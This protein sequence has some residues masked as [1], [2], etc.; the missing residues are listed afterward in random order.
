MAA[1]YILYS[2][3]LKKFYIGSCQEVSI[4]L[5]QHISKKFPGGFTTGAKDWIVYYEQANL[6]YAQARKIE[7]H[8]KKMKSKKYVENLKNFPEMGEKLAKL[9]E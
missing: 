1:V 2:P 3:S 9:Y 5:D 7:S 4:R 6:N 8:I